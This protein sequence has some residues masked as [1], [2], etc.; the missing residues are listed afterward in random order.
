M[1]SS[2]FLAVR[3][4]WRFDN[5]ATFTDT[6]LRLRTALHCTEL[7]Y[8]AFHFNALHCTTMHCT[9]L[10]CTALHRTALHCTALNCTAL[11]WTALHC[12]ALQ[13]TALHCS[14]L[15]CRVNWNP[16]N[17]RTE[18]C[19][20]VDCI[21]VSPVCTVGLSTCYNRPHSTPILLQL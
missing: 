17:R 8:I 11:H 19:S 1:T 4:D 7:H 6:Q 21:E 15:L 2:F 9:A 16:L 20:V 5:F 14:T 12:I 18:Y 13:C 3:S 10:H